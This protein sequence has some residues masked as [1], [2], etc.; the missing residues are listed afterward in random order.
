MFAALPMREWRFYIDDMPGFC[1]KALDYT[2][3]LE[4]ATFRADP[5]R[6]GRNLA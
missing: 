4:R 5:M 6:Y 3:G 2:Q 1:S